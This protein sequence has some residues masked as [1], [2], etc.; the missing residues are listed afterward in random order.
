MKTEQLKYWKR[1]IFITVWL[2]YSTFYL[3]RVNI[4]VILPVIMGEFGYSKAAMG[5]VLT[6]FFVAYSI[7]GVISGQLGDKFGARIVVC[8]G[9]LVSAI[10][11]IAFGFST[12]I[13]LMMIVWGLNGFFQSM[14]WAPIVKIIANWFP[15]EVRGKIGGMMG[16]SYI[17]G[18]AYSWALAG[19]VVGLLGWRWSFWIPGIICFTSGIHWYIRCR[20]APEDVGLSTIKGAKNEGAFD[21][22]RKNNRLRSTYMTIHVLKNPAIWCITLAL[23]SLNIVRYGLLF[24]APTF[25]FEEQKLSLPIAAFTAIAIPIGGS[26]GAIFIGWISDRY[27]RSRTPLAVSTLIMLTASVLIYPYIP[28]DSWTMNII[29]LLTIGFLIYGPHILMCGIMPI[30]IGTRK[31]AST[32][33]G[34]IDG[35]G[36]IGGALSG[37]GTGLVVDYYGWHGAF[38]FWAIAAFIATVLMA[39]LWVYIKSPLSR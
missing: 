24:W 33:T 39:T 28:A 17:L 13:Y 9:I 8:I 3:C 26:L 15:Q 1:R 37:I 34:F 16:T 32:V 7:G 22:I 4:A 19:F 20:N 25:I 31:T 18:N 29:Y 11:N 5:S 2:T 27:H 21:K 30:D 35:V 10:L 12:E 6:S 38:Y 23:L 36:S 14:G